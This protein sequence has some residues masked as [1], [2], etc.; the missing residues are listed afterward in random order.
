[1]QIQ[2]KEGVIFDTEKDTQSDEYY[3]FLNEEVY[4]RLGGEQCLPCQ[5]DKFGRPT[6]YT[7][8]SDTATVKVLREYVNPNSGSW[9]L[10][11]NAVVV[12]AKE[13]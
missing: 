1:M 3:T 6:E 8:E 4:S 11:S 10:K 9:A 13:R 5:K 12:T 2:I 7:F